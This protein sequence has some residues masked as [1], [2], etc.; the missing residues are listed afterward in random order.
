MSSVSVYTCLLEPMISTFPLP[1]VTKEGY[2]SVSWSHSPSSPSCWF[3][4]FLFLE[5]QKSDT[6]NAIVKRHKQSLK[7]ASHIEWG[8]IFLQRILVQSFSGSVAAGDSFATFPQMER[9]QFFLIHDHQNTDPQQEIKDWETA[10][11]LVKARIGEH[12]YNYFTFQAAPGC[13]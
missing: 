2:E 4:L 8:K 11:A 13:V 3:L 7:D 12:E 5:W 10:R 1:R 9:T 6:V